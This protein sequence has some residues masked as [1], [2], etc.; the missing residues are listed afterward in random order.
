V[1]LAGLYPRTKHLDANV[2]VVAVLVLANARLDA[3][4]S[5]TTRRLAANENDML[6]TLE[7]AIATLL[8]DQKEWQ[9]GKHKRSTIHH[10]HFTIDNTSASGCERAVGQ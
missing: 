8:F 6:A 7:T 1:I 10:L 2:G 5:W 9:G 4:G 3:A